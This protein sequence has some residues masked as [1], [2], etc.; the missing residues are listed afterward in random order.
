M[1]SWLIVKIFSELSESTEPLG[2]KSGRYA[3]EGRGYGSEHE[4]T[5]F[6][7]ANLGRS[8]RDTR[9][10]LECQRLISEC[11]VV[12]AATKY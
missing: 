8:P 7:L 5:L 3:S 6:G 9:D 2:N 10:E 1:G 11:S 4:S 12:F